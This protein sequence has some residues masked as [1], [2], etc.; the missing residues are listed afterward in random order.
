MCENR[1]KPQGKHSESLEVP[2]N[3]DSIPDCVWAV[4]IAKCVSNWSGA[5]DIVLGRLNGDIVHPFR[6]R[7][8]PGQTWAQ[9]VDNLGTVEFTLS[10][11]D[12][13]YRVDP[14]DPRDS[15]TLLFSRKGYRDSLDPFLSVEISSTRSVT[16]H[17]ALSQFSPSVARLFLSLLVSTVSAITSYPTWTHHKP[18]LPADSSLLSQ[19]RS[20][21]A[22]L[23][24]AQ[25]APNWIDTQAALQPDVPAVWFYPHVASHVEPQVLSYASLRD[26]SNQF[27]HHLLKLGLRPEERV[28]VCMDRNLD[29]HVTMVAIMKAGGCY[30]PV[31]LHGLFRCLFLLTS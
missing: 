11:P 22:N 18:F 13:Q 23:P 7:L 9:I 28:A 21:P 30:V 4:A 5:D 8:H 31:G 19:Y 25:P 14:F 29:F 6:V 24:H 20:S 26:L 12:F 2:F 1:I 3:T 27:A 17:V 16:A 10:L 15:R